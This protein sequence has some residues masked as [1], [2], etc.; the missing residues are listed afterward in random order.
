MA[1]HESSVIPLSSIDKTSTT[2]N[3]PNGRRIGYSEYGPSTGIP[4][5]FLHGAPGSRIDAMQFT[6]IANQ[7]NCRLISIDRPGIGLSSPV[8]RRYLRD[9]PADVVAV[10]DRLRLPAFR[11][12]GVSGGGPYALS[13]A[14]ALPPSRLLATGVAVGLGPPNAG[15]L[16]MGWGWYIL[17]K[18]MPWLPW[19][20]RW[21]VQ[22]RFGDGSEAAAVRY[23]EDE[24]V[25][26]SADERKA[27]MEPEVWNRA[28]LGLRESVRQGVDGYVEDM[29]VLSQPWSFDLHDARGRVRLW[30]GGKD[31]LSTAEAGQWINSQLERSELTVYEDSSHGTL[32][33]LHGQEVF[34]QLLAE[35]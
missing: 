20:M 34:E 23:L 29:M 9:Y 17:W 6:P 2:F 31:I 27:L 18:V 7:L 26:M 5:V 16:G 19:L 30:Y 22:W 32:L 24:K 12:L 8:T 15:K 10:A 35:G 14:A 28:V 4:I 25:K 3:L 13:C 33:K 21:F 11:V 1:A